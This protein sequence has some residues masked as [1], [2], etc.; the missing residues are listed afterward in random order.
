MC[1]LVYEN[2][3]RVCGV[4]PRFM[5]WTAQR[6]CRVSPGY[7]PG[8]CSGIRW[9]FG[10]H[11][12]MCGSLGSIYPAGILVSPR[13]MLWSVKIRPTGFHL[14]MYL[15]HRVSSRLTPL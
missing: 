3:P 5:S 10:L 1:F 2:M 9:V 6:V 4:S 12:R 8:R 14:D 13:F 15:V 7:V 11:L